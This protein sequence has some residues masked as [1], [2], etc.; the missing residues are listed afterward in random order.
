[1]YVLRIGHCTVCHNARFS[2]EN[3]RAIGTYPVN[4]LV[5]TPVI[6]FLQKL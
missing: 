2:D 4:N 5:Y 3:L 1:M 6:F